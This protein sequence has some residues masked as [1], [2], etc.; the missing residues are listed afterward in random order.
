[1][2]NLFFC[3]C[4]SGVFSV[5]P[6][7]GQPSLRKNIS[8]K[9]PATQKGHVTDHYFGTPVSDP[10]R[11]L[12]NDTA[13]QVQQWIA[14]QNKMTKAYLDRIPFRNTIRK[15]LEDTWN[16]A[17]ET[18]PIKAG[19]YYFFTRNSGMQPQNV[20]F[21]RNGTDG[22]EEVLLDPNKLS[23]KGTTAV[24]MLGFSKDKRYLAYAVSESGSDWNTIHVMDIRTRK[25]FMDTLRWIKF[26]RAAWKG[27]GFFYSRYPEPPKGA[28]LS[29][30]N[31]L[32]QIYFHRIG[33]VQ[34]E[35][36]LVFE[37][38]QHPKVSM[39]VSVTE[40]ERFLFISVI[41]GTFLGFKLN[42]ST[43]NA[44]YY[45][46]LS[47]GGSRI[48]AL[49]DEYEHHNIIVDN[50]GS[51]LLLQTDLNAP[52]NRVVLVDPERPE[53]ENWLE[54]IPEQSVSLENLD[55][56]GGY[57]WASYLKDAS[58]LVR[59][60][61]YDGRHIRDIS[62]PAIGTAAG[63]SAGKEDK[64]L[65][66]TFTNFTMPVT[67]YRLD[68]ASGQSVLYRKPDFK[69]VTEGYETK[70]V[71]I[72]SKDGTRVPMFIVH[73]KGIRLDGNN[74]VFLQ[75]HGGFK[76]SLM[77]F[78]SVARMM[79]LESGGIY[80]Q[81]TLRGGNEYGEAWHKGGMRANKQNVFDD[82]I[83]VTEYLIW[84]K[85]T[86]PSRIAILGISTGAL[87]VGACINQ[88][89]DLF[90]VAI[91]V[92]GPM[93]MLRYHKFTV[94]SSWVE[95]YGSSEIEEQF[96]WLAKYSPLHNI[97]EGVQY[98]ATLILTGDHDD[99]IIPAH[100]YKYVATL[101]EKQSGDNPV[102]IRIDS[103]AGHGNGKPTIKVIDEAADAWSF[104]YHHL[105][106]EQ[107]Q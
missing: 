32:N 106:M 103:D 20:W 74:P 14:V 104:I 62:F 55:I 41:R 5:S 49:I 22:R 105:E 45:K 83:A 68:I 29:A 24:T 58:T 11:W 34:K 44:L 95:E 64:E 98:P 47:V 30:G 7:Q 12:E 91:P 25:S 52:N 18:P 65:F 94:G 39:A 93:D 9:Y 54:V 23:P 85:Y 40:D 60:F 78:F 3:L 72:A 50:I 35:D 26:P 36:S 77:P 2:K 96:A 80:V 76:R 107:P 4:I 75:G 97:R 38:R 67:I 92:V 42:S 100:S 51:K 82:F 102:L 71:F 101:Q 28:E 84:E 81:P 90:K 17:R 48:R 43:G 59:Q 66:Y 70:Q 21:I 33:T 73:K 19:A 86:N 37:D 63:F 89:P 53:K 1:M 57:L 69:G 8:V 61:T 46:D 87:M 27:N 99:T 10:Y 79:F 56:G 15:H 88:R 6:V 31:T 13:V 16:Y